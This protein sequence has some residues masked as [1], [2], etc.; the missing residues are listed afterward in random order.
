FTLVDRVLF[1]SLPVSEPD[2]LM[3]VFGTNVG[4]GGRSG[5]SYPVY[6]GYRDHADSFSSLAAY[7]IRPVHLAVPDQLPERLTGAIVSGNY[8]ETLGL[9]PSL[10]RLL[11]PADDD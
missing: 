11:V 1:R 3:R 4:G 10:G 9:R 6:L 7:A 5:T 8:F 2:K